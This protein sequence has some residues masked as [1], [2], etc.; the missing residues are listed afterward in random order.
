VPDIDSK[1]MMIRVERG[2]GKK[3][4]NGML[5]PRFLELLRERRLVGKPTTG[6]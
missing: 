1:R 5:S 3:D 6:D 4:R 2:K